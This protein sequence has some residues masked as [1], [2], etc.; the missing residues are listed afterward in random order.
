MEKQTDTPKDAQQL[1]ITIIDA[2]IM[3]KLMIRGDIEAYTEK[4]TYTHRPD[5]RQIDNDS[6]TIIKKRHRI[7]ITMIG[8]THRPA[9][10]QAG[11]R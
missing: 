5:T 9:K 6:V 10:D 11:D 7:L 2:K 8:D 4:T 1:I 3:N